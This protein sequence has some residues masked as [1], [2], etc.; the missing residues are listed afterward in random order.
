[1]IRPVVLA[2]GIAFYP[3]AVLALENSI[4]PNKVAPQYRDVAEKRQAE[5]IRQR[6]CQNK[7]EKE[8]DREARFVLLRGPMHGCRGK[9]RAGRDRIKEEVASHKHD[10]EKCR[11]VFSL[12][13]NAKRCAAIMRKQRTKTRL[14]FGIEREF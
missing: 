7:A 1:M 6:A 11:P 9:S 2:C 3:S 5:L 10:P 8:K 14:R 13:T 12:T 4:D